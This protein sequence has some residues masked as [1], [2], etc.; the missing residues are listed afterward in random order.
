MRMFGSLQVSFLFGRN[1]YTVSPTQA[2][3]GALSL[4]L[5][6]VW[7]ASAVCPTC[8]YVLV[9]KRFRTLFTK[10]VFFLCD[11]MPSAWFLWGLLRP[12]YHRREHKKARITWGKRCDRP[13]RF[14]TFFPVYALRN[15]HFKCFVYKKDKKHVTL[16]LQLWN[17][18][19]INVA[20]C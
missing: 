16:N 12:L 6:F 5:A 8:S 11:A 7:W 14:G 1:L 2:S 17:H 9:R 15:S 19:W 4:R 13:N 10:Q 18:P 3:T 20:F